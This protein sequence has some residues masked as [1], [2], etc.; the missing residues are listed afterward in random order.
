MNDRQVIVQF[1]LLARL[2]ADLPLAIVRAQRDSI[3][4]DKSGNATASATGNR[5]AGPVDIRNLDI[6]A[7]NTA[8]RATAQVMPQVGSLVQFL[9]AKLSQTG[10]GILPA[11]RPAGP[12]MLGPAAPTGRPKSPTG[13]ADPTGPAGSG[14]AALLFNLLK[15]PFTALTVALGPMALAAQTINSTASGFQVV[16]AAVKVFAATLAP[17]LLPVF[18]LVASG[19]IYLSDKL[20]N[21][22]AP[23]L[24]GWYALILNTAVPAV[25][26]L[27][28]GF[29][30]LTRVVNA[31]VD[32]SPIG[33]AAKAVPT[34]VMDAAVSAL[35][36]ALLNAIPGLGGLKAIGDIGRALG[37]VGG[38]EPAATPAPNP[39]ATPGGRMSSETAPADKAANRLAGFQ[40]AMR[41]TLAELK[42]SMGPR[43]SFSGLAQASRNAQLA[44]LNQS[45]FETK[46]LQRMS[47]AI[48]KL[49]RV[50]DNTKAPVARL[51]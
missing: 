30:L 41:D 50:V 16:T 27:I 8:N 24:E 1:Q 19:L 31:I 18:F 13:P 26:S 22:I 29:M 40:S 4:F 47:E 21:D 44:A 14:T 9:I 20:W 15:A 12:L 38:G 43:A 6:D 11:Y 34:G 32:A 2:L 3:S 35:P 28:D 46:I 36:G 10:A 7:A 48:E 39:A 45:P 42:L 5:P 51:T 49:S 33:M 23:A 17:L 25:R 37:L